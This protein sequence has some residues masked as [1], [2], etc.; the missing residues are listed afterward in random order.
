MQIYKVVPQQS[1]KIDLD[2]TQNKETVS[3]LFFRMQTMVVLHLYG[4][5][6]RDQASLSPEKPTSTQLR[7]KRAEI[8]CQ[9]WQISGLHNALSFM[10]RYTIKLLARIVFPLGETRSEGE[11]GGGVGIGRSTMLILPLFLKQFLP[12]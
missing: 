6:P 2:L 5:I 11:R 12:T 1:R 3:L 4:N 8:F 9:F 10:T 7:S